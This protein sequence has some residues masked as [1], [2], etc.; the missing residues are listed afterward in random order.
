MEKAKVAIKRVFPDYF[1]EKGLNI[2]ALVGSLTGVAVMTALFAWWLAHHA[3]STL[4]GKVSALVCVGLFIVLGVRFMPRWVSAWSPSEHRIRPV[5][6]RI[7]WKTL[8]KVF[9]VMLSVNILMTLLIFAVQVMLGARGTLFEEIEALWRKTDSTHYLEIAEGWYVNEGE[10]GKLVQLVFLPGYPLMIRLFELVVGDY[11]RAAMLVSMLSFSAAGTVLYCLVRLD[12]SHEE[13]VR[14]LKYL[15]II[16]GAF[17]FSGVMTE[18]YFLLLSVLTVYLARRKKWFW[19][20][21]TGG[22]AAF[23]R[24]L[25]LMLVI[26]VCFELVSCEVQRSNIPFWRRGRSWFARSLYLFIIPLGF[27]VY[28]FI[29]KQVSGEWFKFL[30][31]E[32][33]NWG[34]KLGLFFNTA[35][36]QMEN[37][38]VRFMEG[39]FE[40]FMGLWIPGLVCIFGSLL[41]MCISAKKVRA[42]YIAYFIAYFVIAIGATW[43]LSAPRYLAALFPI[44]IGLAKMAEDRTVDSIMTVVMAS[45]EVMYICMFIWRWQVW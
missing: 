41:V 35:S 15:C 38:I 23:T 17:F 3:G 9:V 29:C 34:Q 45:V 25:G 1:T 26:P 37:A 8:A 14:T 10:W 12:S 11:F 32:A 36:Y 33:Q 30:E 7:T 43:L 6:Q 42:S 44:S 27:A 16:P 22:L 21:L 18:S 13:A 28:C 5:D 4:A 24:S 2:P 19:S 39:D 31:Y 20:C 40:R